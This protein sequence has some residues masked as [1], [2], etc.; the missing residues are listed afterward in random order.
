[1]LLVTTHQNELKMGTIFTDGAVFVIQICHHKLLGRS[2][3]I[4]ALLCRHPRS[5][6]PEDYLIDIPYSFEPLISALP[7]N[8]TAVNVTLT[9]YI[10]HKSILP[11]SDFT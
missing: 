9:P 1:M 8:I 10:N 3:Q 11:C 7:A 5:C 2:V 6:I 4:L